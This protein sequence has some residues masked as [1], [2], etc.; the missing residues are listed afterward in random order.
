MTASSQRPEAAAGDS[1]PPRREHSRRR[2]AGVPPEVAARLRRAPALELRQLVRDHLT[3]FSLV[4]LRQTLLN[5]FVDGPILDELAGHRELTASREARAAL[6]RHRRTSQATAM[7]LV[8]TLF[9]RE[10]ADITLDTRIRPPVRRVAEKYLLQRLPQLAIGERIA[11]ARRSAPRTA[12]ELVR[13][14]DAR[15]VAAVLGNPRLR[16]GDV[17]DAAASRE[18]PARLLDVI[19]RDPRFGRRYGVRVALCRNPSAPFRVLFDL[20]P[21]LRH[22]DLE[23]VTAVADHAALVRGRAEQLLEARHRHRAGARSR[24]TIER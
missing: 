6:A 8:P 4:D 22:G 23:S 19:A 17:L 20:L 3:R 16:E 11:L 18:T 24:A 5:P 12:A 13:D 14:P 2:G 21:T 1:D 15:V 7:R 9:W 10:L